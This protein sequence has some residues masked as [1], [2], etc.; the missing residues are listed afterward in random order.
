[1]G[2]GRLG[3]ARVAVLTIIDEEFDAVSEAVG[4]KCN[5]ADSPYYCRDGSDVS[6]VLRRAP[7]RSQVPA[8][9]V[10]REMLED[11]QPEVLVLIGIAGGIA[12]RDDVRTGDVVVPSYLHYGEFRK[13]TAQGDLR[14][15]VAFD[16]PSV[17]MRD[18]YVEPLRRTRWADGIP[19]GS[20]EQ[21][22][23]PKVIVGSLVAGEKVYGDPTHHEQREIVR[24]FADAVA[25]DMESYGVARAVFESRR[26]V[27]YNPRLLIVRGI[28][29]LVAA[30]EQRPRL[31]F[32]FRRSVV[33]DNGGGMEN[34]EQRQTWKPYAAAAA[35]TFTAAVISRFIAS[36]DPRAVV[37]P[38]E[39]DGGEGS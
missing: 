20:P 27:G 14:R 34:N 6:V 32:R 13:L 10:A 26:T 31:R 15:Y 7:D 11:Y 25:V 2:E 28:S 17:S 24:Q 18:S 4:L 1:V 36:P 9:G 16:Q 12:G 37:V 33:V 35:A 5:I 22:D 3:T 38:G 30:A 8:M 19:I 23:V 21:N 39:A 29:D